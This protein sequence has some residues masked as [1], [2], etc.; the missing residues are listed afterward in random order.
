MLVHFHTSASIAGSV[1]IGLNLNA[2]LSETERV[3]HTDRT[4]ILE[5]EHPIQFDTVRRLPIHGAV[6]L[7][8][9]GKASVIARQKLAQHGIGLMEVDDTLKAEFADKAVLKRA[10]QSFNA[11]LGLRRLRGNRF[12]AQFLQ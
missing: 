9:H 7:W 11:S 2:M 1:S 5:G 10:K 6:L 4:Q 8:G 12:D 3:V